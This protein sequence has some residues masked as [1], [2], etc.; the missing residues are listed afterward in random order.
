MRDASRQ[1]LTALAVTFVIVAA[2]AAALGLRQYREDGQSRNSGSGAGQPSG[3]AAAASDR[4]TTGTTPWATLPD[5]ANPV[6]GEVSGTTLSVVGFAPGG[7]SLVL[8]SFSASATSSPPSV[9]PLPLPA[10]SSLLG[11]ATGPDGSRWIG[12]NAMLVRVG[13][14]GATTSFSVPA[15]QFLLPSGFGGPPGPS[16]APPVESG[17]ITAIA[18]TSG[19][20]VLGRRGAAELTLFDPSLRTFSHVAVPSGLGDAA[21]FAM[22]SASAVFFSV[23]HSGRTPGMGNDAIG[24]FDLATRSF[25]V[26]D[27]PA[28]SIG[29]GPSGHVVYGGFGTGILDALG[30][31]VRPRS[32]MTYDETR[33]ALLPGDLT[34][35]HSK[36]NTHEVV[37][38]RADGSEARRVEYAAV[39]GRDKAGNSV[40]Y[41]SAFSFL[42]GD[43]AGGVWF[44]LFGRPEIYR[45][46]SSV[47]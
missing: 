24:R 23:N 13:P 26:L 45:V 29:A 27:Q 2:V 14:D 8:Y 9:L 16:G 41:S 34:V 1:I 32:P 39:I 22:S 38:L 28:R 5:S 47:P 20:I 33:V 15:P 43:V 11:L 6:A 18:A 42:D 3:A 7:T 31:T 40:P 46:A 4:F 37:F 21:S 44:G 19:P 25:R 35:V 12:E 30:A 17:Q 36:A 10:G